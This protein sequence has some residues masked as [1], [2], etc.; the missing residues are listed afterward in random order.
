MRHVIIQVL[1]VPAGG[2]DVVWRPY[3]D[4]GIVLSKVCV[5]FVRC[6][7]IANTSGAAQKVTDTK[8]DGQAEVNIVEASW[9]DFWT[10][11]RNEG[12]IQSR[13]RLIFSVA[14]AFA[15]PFSLSFMRRMDS[16]IVF[17]SSPAFL[18]RSIVFNLRS[19]SS[20]WSCSKSSVGGIV[21]GTFFN[22]GDRI[23]V[24]IG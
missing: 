16:S 22:K 15:L 6:K 3:V 4:G 20:A 5:E 10:T 14:T 11:R 17:K 1:L 18:A 2:G 7:C 19:L 8:P 21:S 9:S 12:Y 13:S 23:G 24:G